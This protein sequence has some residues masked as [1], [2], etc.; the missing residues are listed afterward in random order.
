MSRR[1]PLFSLGLSACTLVAPMPED[2]PCKEVGWAYAA[3]TYSCSGDVELANDRYDEL[4]DQTTCIEWAADDPRLDEIG[5]EDLFS[6]AFLIRNLPCETLEALD[7]DV[8]ALLDL[9][10][11]CDWVI[12]VD[13]GAP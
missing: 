2:Q 13:G 3:R 10:P 8:Q 11:S 12:Q 4:V 5:A 1:L 6:C 7:G 9:D